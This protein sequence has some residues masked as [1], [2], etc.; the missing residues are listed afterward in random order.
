MGETGLLF[1][2]YT[3]LFLSANVVALKQLLNIFS[4]AFITTLGER[5][6]L[7]QERREMNTVVA[8]CLESSISF[9]SKKAACKQ[10]QMFTYLVLSKQVKSGWRFISHFYTSVYFL[11]V[12]PGVGVKTRWC[13][14]S[15]TEIVAQV[16]RV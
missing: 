14:A 12:F 4:A 11:L 5:K 3:N 1:T 13:L 15:Q 16:K 6:L 7:E 2:C 8:C 10:A 9:L